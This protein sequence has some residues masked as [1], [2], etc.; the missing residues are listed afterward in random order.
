M[1]H[2]YA[3]EQP[4]EGQEYKE[5]IEGFQ[6]RL[7]EFQQLLEMK[8]ELNDI[9]KGYVWTSE[10]LATS[11]FSNLPIPAFTRKDLVYITPDLDAWRNFF[12]KVYSDIKDES[13]IHY[14]QHLNEDIILTIAGHELVH[15]LDLFVDEFEEEHLESIWFEEGMC[16]YLSRRYLLSNAAFEEISSVELAAVNYYKA[17][18]G[19]TSIDEF[20]TSTYEKPITNIMF[21]YKRSF[22]TIKFLVEERAGG[23]PLVLFS[24]Y[25]NWHDQGRKKPLADY[26]QVNHLF[27]SGGD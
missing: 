12:L 1:K 4:D 14:Y 13:V 3:F 27:R 6:D 8:F 24:E 22:L 11:F 20:G 21:E 19:N 15:H 18:F 17:Q 25:H 5:R 16:D 10:D 26:F 9:P 23:D 2:I 7:S